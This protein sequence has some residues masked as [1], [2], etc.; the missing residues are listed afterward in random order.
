[1]SKLTARENINRQISAQLSVAHGA[2]FMLVHASD[3]NRLGA[4]IFGFCLNLVFGAGWTTTFERCEVAG[5]HENCVAISAWRP[6]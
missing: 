6:E 2:P 5:H 1:M 3:S 4:S